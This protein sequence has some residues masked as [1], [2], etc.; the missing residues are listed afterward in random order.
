RKSRSCLRGCRLC[1]HRGQMGT[2]GAAAHGQ[3]RREDDD[4]HM[5]PL[6][7]LE[8]AVRA[9]GEKRW[10]GAAD[11][12]PF[13]AESA[14]EGMD[15]YGDLATASMTGDGNQGTLPGAAEASLGGAGMSSQGQS[16]VPS[17]IR[18][19]LDMAWPRPEDAPE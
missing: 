9:H 15:G 5:N 10:P 7:A 2:V 6:V 17:L 4:M 14:P 18:E 1:W 19:L 11:A 16:T 8:I 12:R 13:R 3:A